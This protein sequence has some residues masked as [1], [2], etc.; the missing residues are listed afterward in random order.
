MASCADDVG[1]TC[2]KLYKLVTLGVPTPRHYCGVVVVNTI[3]IVFQLKCVGY[4][5]KKNTIQSFDHS[6]FKTLS[7]ALVKANLNTKSERRISLSAHQLQ[8]VQIFT[9]AKVNWH[10]FGS[11]TPRPD[12]W[13]FR[14]FVIVL[15]RRHLLN[16][17]FHRRLN[18]NIAFRKRHVNRRL[19]VA[20]GRTRPIV[21]DNTTSAW[22]QPEP[23]RQAWH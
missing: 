4:R 15:S 9:A 17:I 12:V 6:K 22:R 1:F 19:C 3:I 5:S 8:T 21:V 14:L 13:C 23:G 2:Q 7:A 20:D 16:D 10:C 18:R 11:S